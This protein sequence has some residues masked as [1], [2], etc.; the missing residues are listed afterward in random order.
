MKIPYTK[1]LI[2]V[3]SITGGLLLIQCKKK[4]TGEACFTP[5]SKA[6]ILGQVD[7]FT[8]CSVDANTFFWDFGDTTNSSERSPLKS[9]KNKGT[10]KVQ[11][12]V[13]N[14]SLQRTTFQNIIVG[15]PFIAKLVI[16]KAALL[17][18]TAK[19]TQMKVHIAPATGNAVDTTIN[20]PFTFPLSI[21]FGNVLLPMT[22]GK[23]IAITLTV[24]SGTDSKQSEIDIT[25]A[26]QSNAV[27]AS[28]TAGNVVIDLYRKVQ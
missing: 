16:S 12:A 26:V 21:S 27:H 15:D 22:P 6:I 9:F 17:A 7:T 4:D 13:N 3:A 8:N 14:G 1:V 20:G 10:Y 25:P 11:L 23:P 19:L 5:S 24:I 18:D 28:D 2:I